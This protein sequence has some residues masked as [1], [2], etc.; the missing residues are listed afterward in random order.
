MI[1]VKGKFKNKTAR[2]ER[3]MATVV[4]KKEKNKNKRIEQESLQ[5]SA[6]SGR[7]TWRLSA[8]AN[9]RE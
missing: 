3:K 4:Q 7:Q 9:R 1:L 5:P 8:A 2:E 6:S